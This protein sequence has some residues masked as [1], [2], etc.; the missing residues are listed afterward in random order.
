MQINPP[1][2]QA[3]GEFVAQKQNNAQDSKP[4]KTRCVVYDDEENLWSYI[5]AAAVVAAFPHFLLDL[6]PCSNRSD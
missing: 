1:I 4:K 5:V 2:I 3:G 6:C